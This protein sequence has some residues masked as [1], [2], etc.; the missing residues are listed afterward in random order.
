[1][2]RLADSPGT[3]EPPCRLPPL[4]ESL[5]LQ[6]IRDPEG[7][8]QVQQLVIRRGQPFEPDQLRTAFGLLLRRHA[9]LR[10]AFLP[11]ESGHLTARGTNGEEVPLS[12]T[13][14]STLDEP[15]QRD[16][17]ADFLRMDR[18]RGFDV[19][20]APLMRVAVFR[21][22]PADHRLVWTSH[23]AILDGRSRV[24][25]LRELF[26]IEQAS[27]EGREPVLPPAPDYAAS[28]APLAGQA[29]PASR[30]FWTSELS[31]FTESTPLPPPLE[32][33]PSTWGT[34]VLH[35]DPDTTLRLRESA[36]RHGV[37]LN[38][39]VQVAWAILLSRYSGSE[40]VV[41]GATRSCRHGAGIDTDGL[42]GLLINTVPLRIR[43]GR[44]DRLSGCLRRV[45][46]RWVAIRDHERTP[47]ECI[48]EWCGI[49][50]GEPL[51]QSVVVF[52]N[53][54]LH[55]LVSP[56]DDSWSAELLQRP[57]VPLTL[58]VFDGISLRLDLH[59]EGG[60]QGPEDAHRLLSQ[61][62]RL[63]AAMADAEDPFLGELGLLAPGE[64]DRVLHEW[65][66]T[67]ASLPGRKRV[68][69][70]F[71]E[72][73]SLAPDRAALM[74]GGESFSYARLNRIADQLGRRLIDAGLP[75]GGHVAIL[76]ERSPGSVAATL[77]I[78]KAGGVYVPLDP[79]TPLP[80]LRDILRQARPALVLVPE[81]AVDRWRA[82]PI[83]IPVLGWS[84]FPAEGDAPDG[85]LPRPE[86]GNNGN[87]PACI[88]FTSGSTGQPK[89]V[90]VPHQAIVRLVIGA[91]Y[92]PLGAGDVVGHLSN[93]AFDAG[94]F[95]IWGALLNGATLSLIQPDT[96][97][98]AGPLSRQIATEGLTTLFLTTALF[99]EFAREAPGLFGSLRYLLVGGERACPEAF[100]AVARA[101][102]PEN[103][104]NVYG[105]TEATTFA[106]AHR[107]VPGDSGDSGG[108][109]LPIGRPISNTTVYV[110]DDRLE[111]V[112]VGMPGE[113]HIGGPGV[114]LGYAGNPS[115]TAERFIPDPF[116]PGSGGR[117]Y[118]TG[119]LGRWLPDGTIEFLGRIDRQLKLRGFRI[120]PEEI[121]AALD[122]I[123][124]IAASAVVGRFEDGVCV[125]LSAFVVP[126]RP[127]GPEALAGIRARLDSL[128]PPHM[129]PDWISI[130]DRLPLNPNGKIDRRA[131]SRLSPPRQGDVPPPE[132]EPPAGTETEKVLRSIWR[133]ILGRADFGPD[134][135]FVALGGH[136]LRAVR[137][138]LQIQRRFG[139]SLPIAAIFEAGT[140]RQLAERIDAARPSASPLGEGCPPTGDPEGP[141]PLTEVEL[142]LWNS[143]RQLDHP[144]TM[145]IAR[146]FR[147]R[148]SLDPAVLERSI[149]EILRRH[150]PLRTA[151]VDDGAGVQARPNRVPEFQLPVTDLSQRAADEAESLAREA[152]REFASRPF[153]LANDGPFRTQL[154]RLGSEDHL[155]LIAL[156][157]IAADGWSVAILRRELFALCGALGSGRPNPLPPLAT[158]FRDLA[159][160]EEPGSP[161]DREAMMARWA[162][163]LAPPLP[164]LDPLFRRPGAF[165]P[166]VEPPFSSSARTLPPETCRAIEGLAAQLGGTVFLVLLSVYDLL[167]SRLTGSPDILVGTAVSGRRLPGSEDLVGS[168]A[169]LLP[170]RA[171]LEGCSRFSEFFRR[172][173]TSARDALSDD[174]LPFT[175]IAEIVSGRPPDRPNPVFDTTCVHFDEEP[176]GTP[177]PAGWQVAE[178]ENP[179]PHSK[180]P[181]AFYSVSNGDRLHLRFSSQTRFLSQSNLDHL[182]D[183]FV[184]LLDQALADPEGPLERFSLVSPLARGLLPDP[185]EPL[186]LPVY[187]TVVA[188]FEKSVRCQGDAPAII[189]GKRSFSYRQLDAASSQVAARLSE[190]GFWVGD[191]VA[192][193]VSPGGAFLPALLGT[194]KAGGVVTLLDGAL[195]DLRKRRML[196][197]SKAR[198]L[199][200]TG[201]P[202]L[203]QGDGPEPVRIGVPPALADWLRPD[204]ALPTQGPPAL[205][206]IATEDPA[207]LVFTS[208]TTGVPHA[209][210]GTH[211][212]L[213]HFIDWQRTHFRVGPADRVAQLTKPSFDVILRDIF[214]PLASGGACCLPDPDVEDGS[215]R[216]LAWLREARI[217]ILHA[218]PTRAR[219]WLKPAGGPDSPRLPDLRLVFFSGE[220]LHRRDVEAWRQV[221]PGAAI[222]NLYGPTET[223]LVKSFLEVPDPAPEGV[224][225][226]GHPLPESQLLVLDASLRCCG[227]GEPG[228]IAIRSP[229]RTLGYLNAPDLQRKRFVQNPHSRH[230]DDLLYLTGDRGRLLATGEVEFLGRFDLQ[231]KIH[232]VRVEPS[233]VSATILSL[234]GVAACHVLVAEDGK[235]EPSLAAFVVPASPGVSDPGTLRAGLADLLPA[236]WIPSRF[237][238]LDSLPLNANGKVDAEALR[239]QLSEAGDTALEAPVGRREEIISRLFA[240]VLDIASV[241]RNDDFFER[242]GHSLAAMQVVSRLEAELGRKVS[243]RDLMLHPTP[244]RLA[245][246]LTDPAA[247]P[248][249]LPV[250]PGRPDRDRPSPAQESMWFLHQVDPGSDAVYNMPILLECRGEMDFDALR[251]T[252]AEIVRRHEVLRTT[253]RPET[254][255]PYAVILPPRPV[256]LAFEDVSLLPPQDRR[257]A[258]MAAARREILLPFDL[259]GDLTLRARVISLSEREFL[260]VLCLHHISGD[261]VSLNILRRELSRFYAAYHRGE[262]PPPEDPPAQYSDFARRQR[263]RWEAGGHEASIAY[264][265]AKLIPAPEPTWLPQDFHPA[266]PGTAAER[267]LRTFSPDLDERLESACRE[268]R[269]SPRVLLLAAYQILLHRYSGR[270]QIA[271]GTIVAGRDTPEAGETIGF[272]G[273]ALALKT[274]LSGDPGITEVLSRVSR[275][276][277]ESLEHLD[278]PFD[279]VVGILNPARG[280]A[281]S[282]LFNVFFTFFDA[283]S[284]PV[285]FPG[286]EVSEILSETGKGKLDLTLA[287]SRFQGRWVATFDYRSALF[288]RES[289]ALLADRYLD[290]VDRLLSQGEVPLSQIPLMDPVPDASGA[291][292]GPEG[293]LPDLSSPACLHEAFSHQAART[294]DL[295]AVTDEHGDLTYAQLDTLSDRLACCLVRHGVGAESRIA[296]IAERS[297]EMIIGL[298]GILKAGAA[299]VP[300][301]PSD[302]EERLARL[303]DDSG[304]GLIV[305]TP[306]L[307]ARLPSG[308]RSVIIVSAS[309]PDEPAAEGSARRR[310]PEVSPSQACYV[311]YTSGSTGQPKGVVVEHRQVLAYLRALA[312]RT[313]WN[314]EGRTAVVQPLSV[315]ATVTS[316]FPPLFAG[317]TLQLI[318]KATALDPRAFADAVAAHP[319]DV[320]KLAPSHLEALLQSRLGEKLLPGKLLI[321]GGEPASGWLL[322]RLRHLSP[323]CRVINH[324]GPTETTVGVSTHEVTDWTEAGWPLPIG[325]EMAHAR[326]HILD[327]QMAPVPSGLPG[328][329]YVGGPAV[330][331]GYHRGPRL[332]AAAYVPD[333]FSDRPGSRLYATGDRARRLPDGTI[334]FLGR[335]DN[336]IK[337]RGRRVDPREIES[338]LESCPG[339]RRAIVMLT[340]AA[341]GSSEPTLTAFL[342]TEDSGAAGPEEWRSFLLRQLPAALL[343]SRFVALRSFPRTPHGKVDLRELAR[344]GEAAPPADP[345]A[346]PR[347]S[348]NAAVASRLAGLW[349]QLLPEGRIIGSGDDFFELGGHSLL[350]TR[351][352][353]LIHDHFGVDLSLHMILVNSRLDAMAEH[354][355][356][357]L[358]RSGSSRG[359]PPVPPPA[360]T[361]PALPLLPTQEGMWFLE[362]L[363]ESGPS[364]YH[365]RALWR[366]RGPLDRRAF[367]AAW[368]DLIERHEALRCIFPAEAGSPVQIVLPH[369]PGQMRQFDL[370]DGP[371]EDLESRALS[372]AAD[373]LKEPLRLDEGPLLRLSLIQISPEDHLFLFHAH[374]LITDGW[375]MG[376]IY[377][378]IGPLY[379][380][381]RT[382]AAAALPA[383]P[384]SY[385]DYVV[386]QAEYL[387]SDSYR[388]RL[389]EWCAKLKG[390]PGVLEL[391]FDFARPTVQT[392]RGELIRREL[393][394]GLRQ[395]LIAFARG[396]KATPNMAFLSGLYA[397][398]HRLTGMDRFLVGSAIA[399]RLSSEAEK[400]V[401]CFVNTIV[402]RGDVSGNPSYRQLLHRTW[403]SCVE[404]LSHQDIPFSEVVRRLGGSRSGSRSPVFQ[405]SF[406]YQN[407]GMGSRLDLSG[408]SLQRVLPDRET[409]KFDL[410]F[411]AFESTDVPGLGLEYNADLFKR[412]TAESIL[413]QFLEVLQTMVESPDA[414]VA[415]PGGAP[416]TPSDRHPLRG[417]SGESPPLAGRPGGCLHH[418]FEEQAARTPGALAVAMGEDRLTYAELD[419]RAN[420]LACR[421]S[422]MGA[423]PEQI[424]AVYLNRSV[425]AVAAL[426]AILKA[427]AAYLPL[428]LADPPQRLIHALSDSGARI[429]V[430]HRPLGDRIDRSSLATLWIDEEWESLPGSAGTPP[431]G[432][433]SPAG[434]ACLIYTSG[435]TGRPKGVAVPHHS[436]VHFVKTFA[437]RYG[438]RGRDRVSQLT[439]L[440]FDVSGEEI[441]PALACG[442]SVHV[443]CE[444]LKANPENLLEWLNQREITVCILPT[445]LTEIALPD[446]LPRVRHLRLLMT[447]GD[448]L[449]RWPR[450]P[451]PFRFINAYG[452]TETTIFST[453]AEILEDPGDGSLPP[454]GR[455]LENQQVHLLGDDLRPVAPGQ[456]GEVFIGGEG[457][458]RGYLRQPG[459]TAAR[460]LPDPFSGIPGA[461]LYRTGDLARFLPDGQLE[462]LGRIDGQI[463]IR[464]FRVELGEIEAALASHPSVSQCVVTS[465]EDASG[466][467]HLIAHVI[468][469]PDQVLDL[470]GMRAFLAGRLPAAMIPSRLSLHDAFPMTASG[471]ILRSAIPPADLSTRQLTTDYVAPAGEF[472]T[473]IATF[474]CEIIGAPR[475]GLDDDFFEL[476]GHSLLTIRLLAFVREQFGVELPLADFYRHAT[477]REL[478]RLIAEVGT[479]AMASSAAAPPAAPAASGAPE[480]ADSRRIERRP[481]L[482][483]IATG[484]LPQVE[485]ASIS[486]LRSSLYRE[487]GIPRREIVEEWYHGMPVLRSLRQTRIGTTGGIFLPRFETNIYEAP[488]QLIELLVEALE[489][490]ASIGA[491]VVSLTG[492]VPSATRYGEALA[493]AISGRRDLPLITTGHATTAS[494]VA[495][496]LRRLVEAS[497]RGL[498]GECLGFL[499]LGSIGLSSLE[500]ILDRLPHPASILLCDLYLKRSLLEETRGRLREEHGYQG[501]VDII[502]SQAGRVP[503]D[504]YRSTCI[505]GATNVPGILDVPSL[506]PGTLIV[507]DSAPHCFDSDQV[508]RRIRERGDLLVTEGGFVR[509]P[510]R[511]PQILYRP[512]SIERALRGRPVDRPFHAD[513]ITGCVLSALLNTADPSLPRTIGQVTIEASRRHHEKLLEL[514]FQPAD[515][516]CL[517]E[518]IPPTLIETFR[519]RFGEAAS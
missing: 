473:R 337:V 295:P 414:P 387:R 258:A 378:E 240:K 116:T 260:L 517:G 442:A 454:V 129:I 216:L 356:A 445:A 389:K 74:A 413:D 362:H 411:T 69:D 470:A 452:P 308:P 293:P 135:H 127:P 31:G 306:D 276:L 431:E 262:A 367:E 440:S 322:E 141:R 196:G 51:F 153:D 22:G 370:V 176:G 504:F 297:R 325:R 361:S 15:Q 261:G 182:L 205:P 30:A 237:R 288:R 37:T 294:P 359:A 461:R 63:L 420:A 238:F 360:S 340:G 406:T 189:L 266:E 436:L 254:G 171:D 279:K 7:G 514:G 270:D 72:Q 80:R 85:P 382:G 323:S 326:L 363:Q 503:P 333:P 102:P 62:A 468:A 54:P 40:E 111:P 122:S 499:G 125:G 384:L 34:Q 372:L 124:G 208:G 172:V 494:T 443:G 377:R 316:L 32:P 501:P 220:P 163:R 300:L 185:A 219:A 277:D 1:M 350:A 212:G 344:I 409:A 206:P 132:P 381:R 60:S 65:N 471:K 106:T 446:Q 247:P 209:V 249:S 236:A 53:G 232:G 385:R 423:G 265:R 305:T 515:L 352:A 355:S 115:L 73:A 317:G 3:A 113:I 482:S 50:A 375:S 444:A 296:L 512:E 250:E 507:D 407:A 188:A 469:R 259:A 474:W 76:M 348:G 151:Y 401:G 408:L 66:R 160:R 154:I 278:V 166:S 198:F 412:E 179:L 282:P 302:P 481:L 241:G 421:L 39:L 486:Y 379:Q 145:I 397:L 202:I 274:D 5:L 343:P 432:G 244:A 396:E 483:L 403:K 505:V 496:S 193:H 345:A 55:D 64:R 434:L 441:W 281:H 16:R 210:L 215:G 309:S 416:F 2:D 68:E 283:E 105:P 211:R 498:P 368:N 346:P 402:N 8:C 144:E 4:Q 289:I 450:R 252:L 458:T 229:F 447:G 492:L 495:F 358:E 186:P 365:I 183:Q 41:I 318:S 335:N 480:V 263:A 417:E 510:E 284:E 224:Q 315:D 491:R 410:G 331:R 255:V 45:R 273:N 391:P 89:G 197:E 82:E 285:V 95:E 169:S 497:G 230:P 292:G 136:S 472:E 418:L 476:G 38:T 221:A 298:L 24:I 138:L 118:R 174:G 479:P 123:D 128:F 235:G 98:S 426:L 291:A 321:L 6:S 21:F 192:I 374:H 415:R 78:L 44:R 451:L 489:L 157:H 61:A 366:L 200:E 140:V 114:A 11:G 369:R 310:L 107:Y 104:L 404:A 304:A 9:A 149:R 75:P 26:A 131:L 226:L 25:A 267:V 81:E 201:D 467:P 257:D 511:A 518:K 42:V 108:R 239:N 353:S 386:R 67:A 502:E 508:M 419:A 87:V 341:P 20:E 90:V 303:L 312:H 214:L 56:G 439:A 393:P 23:H 19:A 223:T 150:E 465:Q 49:P 427:G 319:P 334:Q 329:L 324:Y 383:L 433:P 493:Q 10:I 91:D 152:F 487:T 509:L 119:D 327:R 134:D 120:E 190:A 146:E 228:E 307:T 464:G 18:A 519:T 204:D 213:G 162:A 27:R 256:N 290:L 429:L 392:F 52:E 253:Y 373:L 351:L 380:A 83:A 272:F 217:T 500:L 347:M 342:L 400:L 275:E 161:P 100:A 14:L 242:G 133:A 438:I 395:R 475:V 191:T 231:A 422:A 222:I 168:F 92:C 376:V 394:D 516:H 79:E 460:F 99:N 203:P 109:S 110:L 12:V 398:L 178:W 207:Y 459:A 227:V 405:V 466:N 243:I 126:D 286:V 455:P 180:L 35:L 199:I 330:T 43:T 248:E 97:L 46:D 28:L 449:R 233:E 463:Q 184:G 33:A 77:G 430:T 251:K 225:S 371:G 170:L 71:E 264:W 47:L 477:V 57:G 13:D 437:V 485:A 177:Y 245:S 84:G 194:L 147:I 137:C 96:A 70:L 457:V 513:E 246:A 187:D 59:H 299:Y 428:D 339:I 148:G 159:A 338:V 336:Q 448:R 130:Q 271:V 484:K 234:Q 301:D 156:H 195:P 269:I 287:V 112:P 490:A 164:S 142:G 167:L 143:S 121:E 280:S 158:T 165:D 181:L 354:L 101:A 456:I 390:I 364:A 155:L 388:D 349:A 17:W 268:R 175:R 462:F 103:L 425:E 453:E 88:L 399:A 29:D 320:L 488:E 314:G 313:G 506:R 218:V 93:P 328:D 424:V 58:S 94:T 173:A 435:S 139:V 332:T 117:L 48:H 478:S 311:I 86:P 36:R 357:L